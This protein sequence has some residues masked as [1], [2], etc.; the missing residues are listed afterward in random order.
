MTK[1]ELLSQFEALESFVRGF[2]KKSVAS[3]PTDAAGLNDQGQPVII[4]GA[5][6]GIT[7]VQGEESVCD[8]IAAHLAQAK[9]L[10]TTLVGEG[11]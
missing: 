7:S 9:T 3:A 1:D 4:P 2:A 8:H 10:A 11:A 6:P 5:N